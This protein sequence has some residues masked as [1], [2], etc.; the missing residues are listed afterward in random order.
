MEHPGTSR[1]VDAYIASFPAPVR[2]LL[3]QMRTAIRGAAPEAIEKMSY[4]MPTF[5][6]KKNLVHFAATKHHIGFYPDPSGIMA[7]ARELE[8]YACSKGTIRFPLEQPLPL[9]LVR[10]IVRFRVQENLKR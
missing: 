1:Q 3:E 10:N 8:G 4:G 2:Q 6:L 5:F 9:D 7:F